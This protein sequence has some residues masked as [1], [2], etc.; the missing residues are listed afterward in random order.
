LTGDR[1]TVQA[2]GATIRGSY[3]NHYQYLLQ[4]PTGGPHPY[5]LELFVDRV[6]PGTTVVDVGAHIGVYTTLAAQ[7]VGPAGRVIAVEPDARNVEILRQNLTANGVEE[8]VEIL[9]VAASDANDSVRFFLD[10]AEATG[11]MGSQWRDP[12]AA[13]R[14][15]EIPTV[16]LDDALTRQ[17]PDLVK[18]DVQGAELAALRG[19]RETLERSP[20]ESIFVELNRAALERAGSSGDE[21]VASLRRLGL[22][23]WLIEEAR[24]ALVPID[25]LAPGSLVT[26]NLL[27]TRA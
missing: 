26:E 20:P 15:V 8:R 3:S 25:G 19:M 18:I 12:L 4:L 11:T 14:P 27:C 16:R 21:L 7:R 1:L 6:G 5:Q 9:E 22:D 24:R 2:H 13:S 10:E 17:E 23:V